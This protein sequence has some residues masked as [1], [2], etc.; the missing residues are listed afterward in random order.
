[1]TSPITPWSDN[2][3]S[4]VH[5]MLAESGRMQLEEETSIFGERPSPWNSS[6]D[7]GSSQVRN[8]RGS[9]ARLSGGLSFIGRYFGAPRGL[10][11]EGGPMRRPSRSKLG[12]VGCFKGAEAD[13][14]FS[15]SSV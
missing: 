14:Q 6:H 4:Q 7:G 2:F 9:V 1:M 13:S 3:G 5:L 12:K 8:G 11:M 15:S 10:A